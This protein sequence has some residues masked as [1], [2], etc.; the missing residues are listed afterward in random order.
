MTIYLLIFF[1]QNI[2]T[3]IYIIYIFKYSYS[4]YFIHN[5]FSITLSILYHFNNTDFLH[6]PYYT[7]IYL[8]LFHLTYLLYI[9]HCTLI[10]LYHFYILY[11]LLFH[12]TLYSYSYNFV[13][14]FQMYYNSNELLWVACL[15]A[16]HNNS[17]VKILM[18]NTDLFS[19][20]FNC[21]HLCSPQV[22]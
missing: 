10:Y 2:I 16:T 11:T 21:V 4:L 18:N 6:I 9:Q 7:L 3:E 19:F 17:E 8:Y 20:S 22:K 14:I 1:I 5:L 13:F 15:S 12:T